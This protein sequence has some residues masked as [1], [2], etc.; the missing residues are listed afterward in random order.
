M[1]SALALGK[2][3]RDGGRVGSVWVWVESS[4]VFCDVAHQDHLIVTEVL[5]ESLVGPTV[6]QFL[7]RYLIEEL[8]WVVHNE[9]QLDVLSDIPGLGSESKANGQNVLHLLPC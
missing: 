4:L 5:P 1:Y 7:P 3:S 8:V 6:H 9:G 2:R